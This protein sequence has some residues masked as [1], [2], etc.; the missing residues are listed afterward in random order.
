MSA[1][2]FL[3]TS[4]WFA[5]ISPREAAHDRARAAYAEEVLG[6]GTLVTTSLVMAEMHVL[7]LRLGGPGAAL[8]FLDGLA[9]DPTHEVI[10][11]DRDLRLAAVERW[12]R[13]FGDQDFSLT[14]AVSFEFMRRGKL[15]R[16]LALDRHFA[17]AGFELVPASP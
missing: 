6:G 10:D 4:G 1:R 17:A 13:R 12:L 14:D 3:D 5:A 11:V 15:R 7:L 9:A 2:L 16:A 8:G